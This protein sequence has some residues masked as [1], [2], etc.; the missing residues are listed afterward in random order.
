MSENENR[1]FG[2]SKPMMFIHFVACIMYGFLGGLFLFVPEN[3]YF[4][5]AQGPSMAIGGV[6]MLYA[7][8]RGWKG[9]KTYQVNKSSN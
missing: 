1:G 3:N 7:A 4:G 9:Y 2:N 8:F 5:L 6:L